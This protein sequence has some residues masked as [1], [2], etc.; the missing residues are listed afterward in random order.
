MP[1]I[2]VAPTVADGEGNSL[3]PCEPWPISPV[4]CPGWPADESEWDP[5]HFDAQWLATIDLW[6][7]VAGAVGLCRTTELPCLDRCSIR[8][9]EGVWMSPWRDASG[10]WRND[11]CGCRDGCSCTQ[12]C[13]VT[14]QG[15]VYSIES[16]TVGGV[17]VP[18]DEWKLLT[19][20]RLARCGGCWPACQNYCD[21][22]GLVVTYMR[23]VPP[24]LDAIRAVSLLAC[25]KLQ[26]CPPGGAGCGELPSGVT[27]ISREGLSMQLDNTIGS[28]DG[29]SVMSTGI[30]YVDRWI[31][32]INPYGITDQ[33]SVWSPDVPMPQIWRTGTIV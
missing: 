7:A 30:P 27:S 3:Y 28:S 20:N 16:V 33:A 29:A 5:A 14:L 24:G 26:Q 12:L 4:C 11:K 17:A 9:L 10:A 8:P 31:A 32:S 25:K 18:A 19:G 1:V 6:R 22:S 15:P 13:T 2:N 21:E 23:G